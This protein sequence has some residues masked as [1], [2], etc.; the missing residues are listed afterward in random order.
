MYPEIFMALVFC[1]YTMKFCSKGMALASYETE[2]T[3][4]DTNPDITELVGGNY[5]QSSN[6]VGTKSFFLWLF[7]S[8]LL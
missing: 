3:V 5:A 1:A 7:Q 4:S 8:V 2:N 6:L